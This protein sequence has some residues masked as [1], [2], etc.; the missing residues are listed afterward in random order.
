MSIARLREQLAKRQVMEADRIEGEDE[1]GFTFGFDP[2]NRRKYE[3]IMRLVHYSELPEYRETAETGKGY[4]CS[5]CQY[6]KPKESSPTSFECG[7]YLFPDRK[8]GCCSAWE[9]AE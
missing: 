1:K 9:K 8:E 4:F 2:T 3:Q 5:T 6:F 7:R